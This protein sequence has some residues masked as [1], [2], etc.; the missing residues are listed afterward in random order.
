MGNHEAADSMALVRKSKVTDS[1]GGEV[2]QNRAREVDRVLFF[3]L[4][5]LDF[6]AK[7]HHIIILGMQQN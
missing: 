2:V 6:K 1:T 7:G 4:T 5:Y 3:L